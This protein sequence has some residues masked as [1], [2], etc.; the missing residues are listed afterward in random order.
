GDVADALATATERLAKAGFDPIDYVEL[1][2]TQT[3]TPVTSVERPARLL[4]AAKIGRTR[5]IDNL[6]VEP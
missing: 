6:A 4:A 3:L 2:D 5:L 1:C